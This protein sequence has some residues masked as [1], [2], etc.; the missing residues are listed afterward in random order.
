MHAHLCIQS[1]FPII[2]VLIVLGIMVLVH[3]FGH[4]L[5]AKLCGVRVEQFSIGFPPRLFGVKIGETDY[6]ISAIPLG[7]YVKMTGESL[8]GENMDLHGMSLDGGDKDAVVAGDPGALTSHP[9]WQR[10]IIGLAGPCGNFVLALALMAGFY[11]FHNEVPVFYDQ[12]VVLDWIVPGSA[13][14]TAGFEPGDHVVSYDSQP[15]PTWEQMNVRSILNL[16]HTVPVVVERNGQPVSLQLPLADNSKGQEFSLG[17]IGLLP[18][19]QSKPVTIAVITPA[20]PAAKAG[21]PAWRRIRLYRWPYLPRG[22]VDHL[23]PAVAQGRSRRSYTRSRWQDL[24]DDPHDRCQSIF[25]ARVRLGA[26]AS[27]AHRRRRALSR[28]PFRRRLPLR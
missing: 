19:I 13:A 12:P 22:R 3:E 2:S 21:H 8:P 17:K 28:W 18:A 11:M 16:N 20:S 23:L 5:A 6:C 10:V 15:N 27:Q 9:R 14:A 24:T 26:L 7:G 4:F 25:R 1:W